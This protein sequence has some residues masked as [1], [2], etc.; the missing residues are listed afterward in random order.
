MAAGIVTSKDASIAV[1]GSYTAAVNLI[2][3]LVKAEVI[4]VEGDAISVIAEFADTLARTLTAQRLT[5]MSEIV[6]DY[7]Q[8]E[9]P[10][11]GGGSSNWKSRGQSGN[12]GK[13]VT[14]ADAPASEKQVSFLKDLLADRQHDLTI[15]VTSVTKGQANQ[16]IDQLKALPFAK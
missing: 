3:E 2:T 4:E 15:D 5:L 7:P 13:T 9:R 1:N 11:S 12:G 14:N 16:Y 10:R 6:P 8:E